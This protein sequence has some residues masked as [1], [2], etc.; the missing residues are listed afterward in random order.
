[1]A[2][3]ECIVRVLGQNEFVSSIDSVKY[4]YDI[5]HRQKK[6]RPQGFRHKPGSATT[7]GLRLH[8]FY[9]RVILQTVKRKQRHLS[10]E[11]SF[12]FCPF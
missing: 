3:T 6:T 9:K 10:D 7:C 1:M 4:F 11:Y 2:Q 8:F 5:E 12:Y